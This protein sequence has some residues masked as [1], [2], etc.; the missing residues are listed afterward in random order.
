MTL[1]WIYS[2]RGLNLLPVVFQVYYLML[3]LL[4]L[5]YMCSH[6]S[7]SLITNLRTLS[8]LILDWRIIRKPK[9]IVPFQTPKNKFYCE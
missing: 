1:N 9:T 4:L 6:W 5:Y 7:L 8:Y 2:F 3:K